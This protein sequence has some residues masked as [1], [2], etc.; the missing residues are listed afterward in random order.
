MLLRKMLPT[1]LGSFTLGDVTQYNL[2]LGTN[3]FQ[4]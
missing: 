3:C 2:E 4:S 1:K